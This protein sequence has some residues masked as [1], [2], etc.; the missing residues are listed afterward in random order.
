[1]TFAAKMNIEKWEFPT[2]EFLKTLLIGVGGNMLLLLFLMML[3]DLIAASKFTPWIIGFNTAM[4]GYSLV[5]KTQ[6]LIARKRLR[7]LS[8]LMGALVT[9][10]TCGLL[11][12]LSIFCLG[13]S[14]LPVRDLLLFL[15]VGT[16]GSELGTLLGIRY[17]NIHKQ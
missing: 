16:I 7:L 6:P 4:S 10:L 8:V 5:E 11:I 2:R 17:F 9:A 15:F 12:G 3:M 1:M 13:E 14:Y